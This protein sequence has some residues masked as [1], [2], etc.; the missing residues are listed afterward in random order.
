MRA[1]Q[2]LGSISSPR[3]GASDDLP[4]PEPRNSEILIKVHAAG[5]TG[6]EVTWPELYQT[7]SRIPGHELSGTIAALGPA[8]SGPLRT[9]QEVFGFLEATRGQGQAEYVV[10][11][12]SEIAPKPTSISHAEAAAL[13][14][15][16]LTA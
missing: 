15:P 9:G 1:V 7:S 10:C 12:P 16:L 13:P 11:S 2:I 14:I 8:Y 6:D 4:K 5:I 3:I